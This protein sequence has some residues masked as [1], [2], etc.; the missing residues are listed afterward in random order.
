[1]SVALAGVTGFYLMSALGLWSSLTDPAMWR[2]AAMLAF[3]GEGK[4]RQRLRLG[5]RRHL[6]QRLAA[7]EAE[8]A[9]AIGGGELLQ[10]RHGQGAEM[11]IRRDEPPLREDRHVRLAQAIDLAEAEPHRRLPMTLLQHRIPLREGDIDGQHLHP[12]FARIAHDLGRRIE[13]HG[14]AV[15]QAGGEHLGEDAL[16]PG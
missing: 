3:I 16:Q 1:M 14:L 10:R 4:E 6:P 11:L 9:E 15:Q 13:A 8:R 5:E 2:L 12:V 7:V